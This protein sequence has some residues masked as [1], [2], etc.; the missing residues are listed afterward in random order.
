VSRSKNFSSLIKK[1][2]TKE[3]G[4][5]LIGITSAQADSQGQKFL[6]EFIKAGRHGAMS[7]LENYRIRTQPQQ[8]LPE[9]QSIIVIALNYYRKQPGTLQGYGKIAR[10]AYGRDYHKVIKNLL[11]KLIKYLEELD[12]KSKNRACVDSAPLLEKSYALRAGLG[13]FGKNTTLIT[14]KFG[15][16][17]LLGE[18]L[19]SI[20]LD[21]DQPFQ[22]GTCGACRRCLDAC[23]TKALSAPGQMDARKCISYLTIEHRGVIPKK[24]ASKLGNRIFGCDICQEVC[25]YNLTHAKPLQFPELKKNKIAGHQLKL[26]DILSLRNDQEY[27]GRFAGSPLMRAKRAGLQRNAKNALKNSKK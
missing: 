15:S 26:Q 5:D 21:P 20:K 3:L 9:A 7:Y 19:T 16:F 10:Y 6:R 25:P 18:V 13:F 4:V 27:L 2:A 11:K 12:P 8:L 24:L 1:Y 17:V 22:G 23:P 14:Q